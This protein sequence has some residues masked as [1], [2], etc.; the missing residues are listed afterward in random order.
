MR[1][2]GQRSIERVVGC[3]GIGLH[4]G[5]PVNMRLLPAPED[6]GI[7]FIVKEKENTCQIGASLGNL[8]N[9]DFSISLRR[10]GAV[11]TTVEHLLATLSSM[12][13]DNLYIELDSSEVPIMDG[14]SLDFINLIKSAGLLEQ[15]GAKQYIKII[16]EIAIS[17]GERSILVRP[18]AY[19]QITYSIYFDHPAIGCQS[20]SYHPSE[21]DF[22]NKIGPARTFTLLR[23]VE[24]LWAKGLAKG[25]SLENA[26]VVGDHDILNEGGLR[27]KDEFVRH[28]ILDLIGDISLLGTP[29]IGHI[30][31]SRSGHALNTRLI[32]EI[33]SRRDCWIWV[34][35]DDRIKSKT[36]S[37]SFSSTR[38]SSPILT[39]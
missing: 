19:S 5:K 27:Y 7:F 36:R 37:F 18:S 14:S 34:T 39:D 6:T 15:G 13:I 16:K 12:G 17:E 4:S 28:K 9:T 22:I 30:M 11:V 1:I 33:L 38:C 21:T 2:M 23:E 3:S 25:G 10:E 32:S 29:I 35:S 20:Y 26:V 24:G 8:S 31:A